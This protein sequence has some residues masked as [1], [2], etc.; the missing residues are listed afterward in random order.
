M[1]PTMSGSTVISQEQLVPAGYLLS[2]QLGV[3]IS[4]WAF[5]IF[6]PQNCC[7]ETGHKCSMRIPKITG[8]LL[9]CVCKVLLL[10]S[11]FRRNYFLDDRLT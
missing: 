5:V 6:P 10:S 1:Q 11:K 3:L 7:S 4:P 8:N 9:Q 2:G